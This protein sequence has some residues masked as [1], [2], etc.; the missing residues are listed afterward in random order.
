MI[1]YTTVIVVLIIQINVKLEVVLLFLLIVIASQ[2][3]MMMDQIIC[4][5]YIRRN[6]ED[7]QYLID[8]VSNPTSANYAKYITNKEL[9]DLVAPSTERWATY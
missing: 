9:H 3:F 5:V 2:V 6:L 8:D 4:N 1:K 7:L